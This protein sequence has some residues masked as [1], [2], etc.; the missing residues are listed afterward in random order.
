M[1]LKSPKSSKEFGLAVLPPEQADAGA[2]RPE[3]ADAAQDGRHR[4]PR[5]MAPS[6]APNFLGPSPREDSEPTP[7]LVTGAPSASPSSGH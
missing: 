2:A 1:K 4:P 7:S 3:Q 5:H 6:P